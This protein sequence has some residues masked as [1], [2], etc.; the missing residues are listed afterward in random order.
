VITGIRSFAHHDFI[1][2][3]QSESSSEMQRG[4]KDLANAFRELWWRTGIV[5]SLL[6]IPTISFVT[7]PCFPPIPVCPF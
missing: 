5:I 3:M 1:A 7:H 2:I 4:V 6:V